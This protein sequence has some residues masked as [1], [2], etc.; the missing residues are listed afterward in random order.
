MKFRY[1][2]IVKICVICREEFPLSFFNKRTASPDGKQNVCR[3]CNKARSKSYYL[4]N[5]DK[6]R[7]AVRARSRRVSAEN[8][9]RVGDY[10]YTHPCVDCGA[11]DIRIL[12]FDHLEKDKKSYD[13]SRL[14]RAGTAWL[15]IQ[16]EIEKCEVR[17]RNCHTLK[18]YERLGT[19]WRTEY[20]KS[21][22]GHQESDPEL[23]GKSQE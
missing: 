22:W 11:N 2:E 15:T 18:T 5:H 21:K 19:T 3:E 16:R 10:L 9:Q 7:K 20:M 8:R 1:T 13:I 12:D 4:N 23:M 14:L 6:H 17:C